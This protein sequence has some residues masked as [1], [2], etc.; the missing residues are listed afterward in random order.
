MPPGLCENNGQC[1]GEPVEELDCNT[2]IEG[3][4]VLDKLH[5]E[6]LKTFI[7]RQILYVN[8]TEDH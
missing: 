2:D 7:V 3:S 6:I 4:F 8:V 5:F 1:D